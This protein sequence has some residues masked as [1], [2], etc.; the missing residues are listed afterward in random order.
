M[1]SP[2]EIAKKKQ[3]KKVKFATKMSKKLNKINGT[4]RIKDIDALVD[5]TEGSSSLAD[6]LNWY[7]FRVRPYHAKTS[8]SCVLPVVTSQF[9]EELTSE[10]HI[11]ENQRWN[12]TLGWSRRAL[13]EET[14]PVV[15]SWGGGEGN[16]LTHSLTHS[17][18]YLLTHSLTHSLTHLLTH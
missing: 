14:D 5:H 15:Y 8:K 1:Q 3:E 6:L 18:T 2:E 4:G 11:Y 9:K 12:S 10:Y 13:E 7:L 16:T 17:L